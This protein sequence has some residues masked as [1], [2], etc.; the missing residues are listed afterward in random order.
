MKYVSSSKFERIRKAPD[1]F[2]C[3]VAELKRHHYII[4][5]NMGKDKLFVFLLWLLYF[6]TTF[7][8]SIFSLHKSDAFH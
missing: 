8:I 3:S 5:Y 6:S 7:L 1:S 4:D 2:W